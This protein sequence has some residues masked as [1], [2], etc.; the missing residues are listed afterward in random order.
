MG[1]VGEAANK[2]AN[3]SVSEKKPT[4]VF[5]LGGPGSGKGTQCANIVQHFGYTH[6]S[7]GDLLRAEI[8]SG[9]ENGTMIQNM[10]KEGKIVPSEVTIKLLQRAMTES[11]NDRFLID[12]F[13]RNEENRA[14]FEDITKIEPA[15]VLF[16]D[17]SEEEMER[18]VLNRNQGREDDN[19]ETIRKR[20]KVF[21]ESSLP[22]IE[23]YKSRRKVRQIDA[24]RP[25]EEVFESVKA[26]FTSKNE[27]VKHHC[28][29]W[30]KFNQHGLCFGRR[31]IW[32]ES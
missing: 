31:N 8:S 28:C 27:K 24:G 5:V 3:R 26:V 21:S 10:M 16:F 14:A 30:W 2:E 29:A 25:V 7:A 18:R 11:G 22:V 32:K 17:C 15:F 13:P 4:V 6:L 19:I 12:G 1:I 20:F 23:H 9:S